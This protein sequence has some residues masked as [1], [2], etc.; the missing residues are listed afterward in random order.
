MHKDTQSSDLAPLATDT[1]DFGFIRRTGQVYVDKTAH[2]QRMLETPLRFAFLARPRRF[3]KSLLISTLKHLYARKNDDLFRG[4]AIHRSGFLDAVE[5][6]PVL[7]LNMARVKG[8]A[9][10]DIERELLR[11]VR[12][13]FRWF[14]L[15]LPAVDARPWGALDDLFSELSLQ[16]G[17]VVVLVDEYDAPVT[18]MIE[19]PAVSDDNRQHALSHLRDF[20][21]TLKNWDEH[22]RFAFVTGITKFV[23]AGMF[24]ALNNL[25]DLS[26][27]YPYATV[28]G[29]TEADIDQFL[30]K[31][32]ARSAAHYACS[33]DHLRQALRR[34]YNGYRFL[35]DSEQVYNPIS[36][37]RVLNQLT[38]PQGARNVR[39]RG[40]PRPWIDT[41]KPYFVFRYMKA[42]RWGLGDIDD[43]AAGVWESFDVRNPPLNALLFQA[44][45]MT[46]KNG[47]EKDQLGFPNAEVAEALHEGLFLAYLG[48]NAGRDS[49]V[50][51][52][53]EDM[54]R[55]LAYGQC[56]EA[57]A[58]FDRI[59]DRVS[60]S[61]LAAESNFQVALHIV[62][63]MIES[64]LD[65]AS[66]TAGR[67]GRSDLVVETYAAVYVFEL[68][69]NKTLQ[70]AM[71]QI[72][73]KGYGDRY[74]GAGKKVIG[75]GLN[76]RVPSATDEGAWTPSVQNFEM[77]EIELYAADS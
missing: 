15:P 19:N 61:E 62:C 17:Q 75:I 27:S 1:A 25:Q 28:C 63:Y 70:E 46:F 40:F 49:V 24:S 38:H 72:Q 22:I 58:C 42:R 23:D 71:A 65:V 69:R 59:L 14:G 47:A 13:L 68:K 44:G 57:C 33:A 74:R 4:L 56:R 7:A 26:Q 8:D 30:A 39:R 10:A 43:S 9:P 45:Y 41:G 16:H 67:K 3:G 55:A 18:R 54:A 35:P 48:K 60:Y 34:Q 21:G 73:A 77:E 37:L 76:F 12:S 11:V 52:L 29:F 31:H 5:P 50:R 32:V 20:Y 66:E 64:V 53:V 6:C 36:Y 2:I 51:D